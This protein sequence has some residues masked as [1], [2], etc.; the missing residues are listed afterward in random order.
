MLKL[1]NM[2]I[3]S[4]SAVFF[5]I[6]LPY[7]YNS[8]NSFVSSIFTLANLIDAIKQD[9]FSQR[10][11]LPFD[12]GVFRHLNDELNS[13]VIA[14]QNNRDRYEEHVFLIYRLIEH[15]NTPIVV[16]D[17]KNR[18]NHANE[19]FSRY[20]GQPWLSVK[21]AS[22]SALGFNVD[23]SGSWVVKNNGQ[24]Y[25]KIRVSR[26]QES[27]SIYSLIL[28]IDIEKEIKSTQEFSWQQIIRVMNHEI[29]NS[30]TPIN[31]LSQA[32]YDE[33]EAGGE[34]Q[35][36]NSKKAL[37]TIVCRSQSLLFF[38]KQYARLGEELNLMYSTVNVKKLFEKLNGLF[39]NLHFVIHGPDISI[40]ADIV[41]LEQLFI[42]I[43]KNS[44][45]AGAC[46]I[47]IY[48]ASDSFLN[49]A[50]IKMNDNGSGIANPGN[51]F[52]PFYTTKKHG[53]G[54]GLQFCRKII[55]L[56]G[57]SFD[58]CNRTDSK[59]VEAKISLPAGLVG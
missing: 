56:H 51:L 50:I 9:D 46:K 30:L 32:L 54:I 23:E 59:G 28:L 41:L 24:Q 36:E 52:V 21:G 38:L 27:G 17:E 2:A 37:Y 55:A 40:C 26:F 1:S 3:L 39:Q 45:E 18:V 19:S 5:L 53:N 15:L 43:L 29:R 44:E 25:Y 42:N 6:Y 11:N 33:C 16:F 34:S 7:A 31:S 57:G 47:E 12:K 49:T 58:L 13:F 8:Y 22:S 48:L 14:M 35:S 10:V 4:I 20:I